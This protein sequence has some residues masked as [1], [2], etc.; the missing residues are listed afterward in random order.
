MCALPK[1]TNHT[2]V[3]NLFYLYFCS[4]FWLNIL[5]YVPGW[6]VQVLLKNQ[7]IFDKFSIPLCWKSTLKCDSDTFMLIVYLKA[8]N[9]HSQT[10]HRHSQKFHRPPFYWPRTKVDII[11]IH[12]CSTELWIKCPYYKNLVNI[13]TVHLLNLFYKHGFRK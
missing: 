11:Y 9:R 2:V 10:F 5:L 13:N 3:K 4:A 1:L 7:L 6:L 8:H 12:N